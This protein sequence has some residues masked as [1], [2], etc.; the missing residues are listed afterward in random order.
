MRLSPDR[1]SALYAA[2]SDPIFA[3]RLRSAERDV[4]ER[5]QLDWELYQLKQDIL[6]RI[7]SALN[8]EGEPPAD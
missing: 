7:W 8:L 1:K 4:I 6:Q 3:L 5:K 2:I